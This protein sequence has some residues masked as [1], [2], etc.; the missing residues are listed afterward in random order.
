MRLLQSNIQ[1]VG[2][3]SPQTRALTVL[4]EPIE[5]LLKTNVT[6]TNCMKYIYG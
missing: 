3:S 1:T 6:D 5:V 4:Y 2:L